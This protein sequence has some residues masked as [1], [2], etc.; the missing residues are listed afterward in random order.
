MAFTRMPLWVSS[1]V[2]DRA[3]ERMAAFPAEYTLTYGMPFVVRVVVLRIIDP[4]EAMSGRSFC[5]VKYVPLNVFKSK[6]PANPS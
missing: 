4:P 3:R 2:S 5:T 6:R 1:A